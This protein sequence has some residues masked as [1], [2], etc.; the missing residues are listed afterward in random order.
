M[1][2]CHHCGK[3]LGISGPVGRSESCPFCRSDLKVCLNCRFFDPGASNQCREP[4]VD[5]VLEKDKA[6]FCEFFVFGEVHA[7]DSTSPGGARTERDHVRAAFDALFS[8]KKR[9]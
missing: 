7:L 5:P 8:P 9:S 1:K 3:D 4:Q 6:N 2:I